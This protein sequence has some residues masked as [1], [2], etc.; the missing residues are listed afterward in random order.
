[1]TDIG[2]PTMI[3]KR[4]APRHRVLKHGT[5]AFHGGG[6]VDCTVRNISP[7]G[8]RIDIANPVGLPTVFT[9]II[10]T[11]HFLRRCHA[12]WRSEQRIGIAFD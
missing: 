6:T 11:D 12:V 4:A 9:L 3:E 1:M 5:L 8:A 2:F 7:N 10:E